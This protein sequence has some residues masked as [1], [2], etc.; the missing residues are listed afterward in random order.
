[1]AERKPADPFQLK[2][3]THMTL[4]KWA[5]LVSVVVALA[6][7]GLA[8]EKGGNDETGPY[9]VV[10]GW[11]Q[12]LHGIAPDSWSWGRTAGIWPESSIATAS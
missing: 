1:M 2:V 12:P 4:Q 8:Q 11:P 9:E 3:G 10:V 7:V 6:S 5:A